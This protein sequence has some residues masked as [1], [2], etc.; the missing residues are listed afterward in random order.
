M[1]YEAQ[2]H[3]KFMAEP[4]AYVV[5]TFDPVSHKLLDKR[6]V[7]SKAADWGTGGIYR[8]VPARKGV[9]K[10]GEWFTYTI[11]ARGNHFATW[12]NGI[13]VVDWDDNRPPDSNPRNGFRLEP[14][15][16]SIQGHDKTTDLTFRNLRIS[17]YPSTGKK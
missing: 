5:E 3:N 15:H 12:V 2:I 1:G 10:D 4:K 13:Q 16:I 17:E 6:K 14:G 7:P 11:A 9:A 8:R